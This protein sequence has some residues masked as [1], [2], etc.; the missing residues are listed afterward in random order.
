MNG[1]EE[2]EML[3]KRCLAEVIIESPITEAN[4]RCTVCGGNA[5]GKQW[6]NQDKGQGICGRCASN[7][8]K[9]GKEDVN[10]SYGKEGVNYHSDKKIDED[11]ES[12]ALTDMYADCEADY[13]AKKYMSSPKKKVSKPPVKPNTSKPKKA[14]KIKVNGKE[15]TLEE[16]VKQCTLEV[17][18]ENLLEGF[19]PMSQGPNPNGGQENPYPAWND[20]MRR[21]EEDTSSS[22]P[23]VF[24]DTINKKIEFEINCSTIEEA[25]EEVE[26]MFGDMAEYHGDYDLMNYKVVSKHP[27]LWSI[28]NTGTHGTYILFNKNSQSPTIQK[29]KSKLNLSE[30][31]PHGN[32]A[33]DAGAGQFDPRSFGPNTK[34]H[35]F[36]EIRNQ[37]DPDGTKHDLTLKC[38]KCGTTQTCRCSKPKRT[39]EGICEKCAELK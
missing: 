18:K 15:I 27:D 19:D 6:W 10:H 22:S 34:T 2:F 16:L 3:V 11:D 36:Q 12:D 20:K 1:K 39:M 9:D 26:E 31:D 28:T 33:K 5:K 8:K 35:T 24:V 29:L 4:L 14:G 38:V 7:M 32:Y 25:Y 21:M 13:Y 17:L 23:F 37:Y 30:S